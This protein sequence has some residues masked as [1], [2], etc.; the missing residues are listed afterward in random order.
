MRTSDLGGAPATC[1]WCGKEI[2]QAGRGRPRKFC[3]PSCKQ[4]AYEQRNKVE[5]TVIPADAVIMTRARADN[6][7][8]G[9]FE[10]RCAAEDIATAVSED[11]DPAEVQD[12][13]RELLELARRLEELK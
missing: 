12:L 5:G 13:C 4:R 10:L 11:A 9:L 7:R 2:S 3:S 6:F 1:H 8:D